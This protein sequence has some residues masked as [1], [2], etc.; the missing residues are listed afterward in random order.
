LLE[1]AATSSGPRTRLQSRNRDSSLSE[2]PLSPQPPTTYWGKRRH[3]RFDLE[4]DAG[5]SDIT[6]ISARSMRGKAPVRLVDQ[7]TLPE[8]IQRQVTTKRPTSTQ[9]PQP[10]LRRV[11][12]G[13][14]PLSNAANTLGKKRT[15]NTSKKTKIQALAA[16]NRPAKPCN[17]P[18]PTTRHL[19]T[20]A[21]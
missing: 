16:K 11:S 13:R 15:S 7:Q 9:P 17:N 8:V 21:N 1:V 20:K 6:A 10:P 5:P 14:N 2:P 12:A 18:A 19:T 4:L 3:V